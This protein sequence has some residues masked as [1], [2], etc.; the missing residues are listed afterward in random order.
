MVRDITKNERTELSW[1]SYARSCHK[2]GRNY[3]SCSTWVP[4]TNWAGWL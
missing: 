2:L 3:F 4:I 1:E